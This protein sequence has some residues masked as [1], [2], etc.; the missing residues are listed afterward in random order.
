MARVIPQP[1]DLHKLAK[2]A[3][4]P[5]GDGGE[6]VFISAL[7]AVDIANAWHAD[8]ERVRYLE[9]LIV[10]IARGIGPAVLTMPNLSDTEIEQRTARLHSAF[11]PSRRCTHQD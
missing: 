3:T 9:S 5:Y 7:E 1:A 8:R 4:G 6:P 11:A 10:K 2:G